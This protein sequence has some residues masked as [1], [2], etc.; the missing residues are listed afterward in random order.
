MQE[1]TQEK[2]QNKVKRLSQKYEDIY[3]AIALEILRKNK[4]EEDFL[5]IFQKGLNNIY[6][7]HNDFLLEIA[8]FQQKKQKELEEKK[9]LSVNNVGRQTQEL[10]FAMQLSYDIA[11][12]LKKSVLNDYL[13]LLFYSLVYETCNFKVNKEI[14]PPVFFLSHSAKRA[15]VKNLIKNDKD[16]NK[17]ELN[18]IFKDFDKKVRMYKNF[19]E[20]KIKLVR[21]KEEETMKTLESINQKLKELMEEK[22]S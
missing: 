1:K 4:Y 21:K 5:S 12:A 16:L 15:I 6:Q 17:I 20:H 10:V 2:F 9:E 22:V 3:S 7:T 19:S 14:Q 8:N 13:D 18:L 11:N